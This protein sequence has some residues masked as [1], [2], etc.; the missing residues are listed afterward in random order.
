M[1]NE[2]TLEE[3]TTTYKE[4]HPK[5]TDEEIKSAYDESL[6]EGMNLTDKVSKVMDDYGKMLITQMEARLQ[7]KIDDVIKSTQDEL[8]ASIRK[9]VGL[10]DDPVIHLSEVSEVV[11]KMI[12]KQSG[13][14]KKTNE[15]EKGGP[16]GQGEKPPVEKFIDDTTELGSRGGHWG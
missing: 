9:G 15:I 8:V 5:A 10:D 4:T 14:G 1:V 12:L 2:K 6:L 16:G 13:D 3:F 7:K 11:R